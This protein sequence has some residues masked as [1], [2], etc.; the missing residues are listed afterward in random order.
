MLNGLAAS[1][2]LFSCEEVLRAKEMGEEV[3]LV[4]Q[5]EG[6]VSLDRDPISPDDKA[7]SPVRLLKEPGLRAMDVALLAMPEKIVRH[8][9][10]SVGIAV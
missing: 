6:M 1:T 5:K 3:L 4:E 10:N 9:I 2:M 8:A 7:T